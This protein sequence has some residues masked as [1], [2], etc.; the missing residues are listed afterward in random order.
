MNTKQFFF[1]FIA[2]VFAVI[3]FPAEKVSAQAQDG[4]RYST[5][6]DMVINGDTNGG[7][8]RTSHFGIMDPIGLRPDERIAITLNVSSNWANSPVGI[9][10]LDGGEVFAPGDQLYVA[11]D[12][13]I[14]FSF[15]GGTTPGLY[16]ILVTI[17]SEQYQLQLYVPKP[18]D[19][20][21][22]CV[23]P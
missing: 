16:R 12:G 3:Y 20:G 7:R 19:I 2:A 17:A 5:A 8:Q 15:K 13:T 9:A 6:I 10:P 18:G 23:N 4:N 14:D 21:P 11:S 1:F 22:D